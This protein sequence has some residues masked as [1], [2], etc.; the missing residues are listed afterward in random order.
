MKTKTHKILLTN[1]ERKTMKHI[2]IIT[3]LLMALL[4]GTANAEPINQLRF[5]DLRKA[6]NP[7]T[8]KKT[9]QPKE[10]LFRLDT[11]G[12][13]QGSE[14]MFKFSTPHQAMLTWQ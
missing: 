7:Q 13:P 1:N 8:E 6:I 4:M 14:R 11:P 5:D 3:T 9:E 12:G 10:E 2:T